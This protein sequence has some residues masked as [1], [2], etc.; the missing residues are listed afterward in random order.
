MT[1]DEARALILP[2]IT[3]TM[4]P[5]EVHHACMSRSLEPWET[6]A[7]EAGWTPPSNW[8]DQEETD[9]ISYAIR[10]LLTMQDLDITCG[11]KLRKPKPNKD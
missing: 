11:F 1:L 10:K 6:K 3:G 4:T 2:K 7:L 5:T 8:T 9:R